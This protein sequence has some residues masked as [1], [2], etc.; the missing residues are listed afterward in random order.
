MSVDLS[1]ITAHKIIPVIVVHDPTKADGLAR[2]LLEGGLP[3]A[4][5]T[6]RTDSAAE[7]IETMAA[8]EGITVGAGTV[9]DVEQVHSALDAGASF[10]VSPGYN[11]DVVTECLTLGVP[12]LP[13]TATATDVTAAVNSGLRTVK[14]FP[15]GSCGG[16]PAIRALSGPFPQVSFVPTGGVSTAN[17]GEYLSLGCVPAVGGS[18]MAPAGLIDAGEFTR[19]TELVAASVAAARTY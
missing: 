6:F 11:E 14:F 2:A 3:V 9:L 15:A 10:I 17:L 1:V 4:E 7:V 12:V 19:I 13:G 8:H 5:V 18:W 16:A